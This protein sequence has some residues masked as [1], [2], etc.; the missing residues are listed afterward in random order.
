MDFTDLQQR[1]LDLTALHMGRGTLYQECEYMY[2]MDEPDKSK[3]EKQAENLKVTLSPDPFNQLN[4][5]ARLLFATDP[6]FAIPKEK[7]DTRAAKKSE[8]IERFC[9]Q[10][11]QAASRLVG[12][13]IHYDA[14]VSALLYSDVD[15]AVTDTQ[16]LV[17]AAKSKAEK[18][19][20]KQAAARTPYLFTV[21]NPKECYPR[22]DI[23]GLREHL[24]KVELTAG[25]VKGI[26]GEIPGN[27]N[28]SDNTSVTL[29]EYW[30]LEEHAVW[31]EGTKDPILLEPHNLPCIPIVSII[32]EGSRSLFSQADQQRQPFLYALA[33]SGLWNRQN[34]ALTL[35]YTYAFAIGANPMF[36]YQGEQEEIPVDWNV[37]GGIVRLHQGESFG[38]VA[39]N[40]IDPSLLTIQQIADQKVVEST[41]YKQSLGQPLEGNAPFSTVALLSQSGRLPLISPQ[42][43][44]SWALGQMMEIA[45]TL[46]RDKGGKQMSSYGFNQFELKRADIPD[47]FELEAK[48]DINLPTD[49]LQQANIVKLLQGTV[50]NE[51]LME[52]VLKIGQPTQMRKEL[53]TEQA[54]EALYRTTVQRMVAP[55][56]MPPPQMQQPQP[57]QGTPGQSIPPEMMM[58]G[59]G[60]PEMPEQQVGGENAIY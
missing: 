17:N 15:I 47:T 38:P 2:F 57:P 23:L 42:R 50:S 4:G 10:M 54:Q 59:M 30:N 35:M 52:N 43:K 40:A 46:M 34:L 25:E 36:L 28:K 31:V 21:R 22:W 1:A 53:W 24:R 9:A 39:K 45:L 60:A 27:E 29:C 20:A 8:P 56:Q 12:Q 19:R 3:W 32:A 6:T 14:V 33:K 51:W 58:G 55:P 49:L 41:I 11:Y 37:P 18:E 26:Y 13:P 44:L 7:N 5:A 48:L 16:S